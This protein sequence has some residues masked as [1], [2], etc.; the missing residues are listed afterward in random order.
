MF[1]AILAGNPKGIRDLEVAN[2]SF[3][4][5]VQCSML[6]NQFPIRRGP[7]DIEH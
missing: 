1:G 3:W 4:I 2:M 7:L 5:N 6:N